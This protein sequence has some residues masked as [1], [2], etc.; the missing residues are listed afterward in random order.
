ME[1]PTNCQWS[2]CAGSRGM[3]AMFSQGK[4]LEFLHARIPRI[5]KH[6]KI[7]W[8]LFS[9]AHQWMSN[10]FESHESKKHKI[11]FS[12]F[13]IVA[14]STVMHQKFNTEP[15]NSWIFG[16]YSSEDTGQHMELLH[17]RILWIRNNGKPRK[18]KKTDR[19]LRF[20]FP[21]T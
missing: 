2:V 10:I 21:K 12:N 14:C 9:S 18:H 6:S 20:R 13:H 17:L 19:I 3:F 7:N 1:V 15:K 8:L 11:T 4:L 5:R 16:S